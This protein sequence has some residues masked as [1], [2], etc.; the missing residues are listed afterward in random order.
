MLHKLLKPFQSCKQLF[1]KAKKLRVIGFS[2]FDAALF[3]AGETSAWLQLV[4]FPTRLITSE[5]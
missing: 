4:S 3:V 5:I 2:D 1:E